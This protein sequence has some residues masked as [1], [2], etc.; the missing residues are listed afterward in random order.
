MSV[1]AP[2]V[3]AGDTAWVLASAAL[4]LIM[5]PGLA[6]FY[7]GMVRAKNVLNTML[8]S[9]AVMAVVG[10]SWVALGYSLA[11]GKGD[12]FVGDFDAAFL[13][14]PDAP[15]PGLE[16]LTV[17]PVAFVVF[18]M[19]FAVIT[20][21]L[22]TGSAVERWRFGAFLPFTLIW[23]LIVYAPIAHW[24]FSP[25]GWAYE[26]GALDF[27][28]GTVV[29]CN[30]GA[31]GLALAV[32]LGRRDGWPRRQSAPHNVPFIL[33][34]VSLL[35]F[36][37][38]GFNAGSA[39]KADAI[40]GYAFLNT[41][42]ATA[43]AVLT[44]IAVERALAQ[45]PTTV[46]AASGAIAGLVAITPCA[47]FVD[48]RGALAVGVAA[49]LCCV[50]VVPLKGVLRVDDSLDVA[51]LHLTGGL[52][53]SLMVGLLATARINPAGADGLLYGGGYHQ[54]LVQL[55]VVGAVSGYSFGATYLLVKALDRL[56]FARANRVSTQD[57]RTGLDLALHN[58]R[59][60]ARQG[61]EDERT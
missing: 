4:V 59:A 32:A 23:S 45:R 16:A 33:L 1:D 14:R 60:Y 22:I 61:H 18:Q 24:V 13:T 26:M 57:E 27:A 56:P 48:V 9:F 30:A 46:G 3:S 53:G 58:E 2:E 7:G 36:G 17:P 51:G 20:P 39:L 25:Y 34:G 8:Q 44:W 37:W 43:A 49:G 50:L 47:G 15:V 10:V 54:L 28:G 41:N 5:T 35:W 29:H 40:A 52:V 42:T 31:A 6:F 38:F 11:F 55:V 19:M 12:A 21:A